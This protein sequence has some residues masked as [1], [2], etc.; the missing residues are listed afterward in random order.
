MITSLAHFAHSEA[1]E[2]LSFSVL[3]IAFAAM[4][5]TMVIW[6]S[7]LP[8]LQP[9]DLTPILATATGLV[10]LIGSLAGLYPR[11]RL[12]AGAIVA[13][14]WLAGFAL[15]GAK[16][17]A[18]RGEVTLL[19]AACEN[20]MLATGL[21]LFLLPREPKIRTLASV[22]FG[23]G[24]CLFGTVHISYAGAIASMI[25]EWLPMR[26]T[27]PYLTGPALIMMGVACLAPRS[28]AYG[29][30]GA[31][32]T[33][34]GWILFIH[35]PRL[36]EDTF[37]HFEWTFALTAVA[38]TSIAVELVRQSAG[39][40]RADLNGQPVLPGAAASEAAS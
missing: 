28:A 37:S 34:L 30:G 19:V 21:I 24:L 11:L 38:L 25:P 14:I 39:R 13:F 16:A 15:A 10:M 26:E 27:W 4:G 9:V 23:I 35:L 12:A 17:V 29:A 7:S 6:G 2:R 40:R 31:A 3:S 32:L 22:T 1:G 5:L 18:M 36:A 20:A 33:F 8:D